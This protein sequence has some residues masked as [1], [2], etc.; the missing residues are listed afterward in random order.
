MR[1]D[2]VEEYIKKFGDPHPHLYM[3]HLSD[4]DYDAMLAQAIK[5]GVPIDPE[6]LVA[7]LPPGTVI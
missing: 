3:E 7:H 4:E 2:H 5:T 1:Y 6:A